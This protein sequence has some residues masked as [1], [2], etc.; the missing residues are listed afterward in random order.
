MYQWCAMTEDP[1]H[2]RRRI[3]NRLERYLE[4]RGAPR[5]EMFIIVLG[6]AA[7][8]FLAS[9]GMLHA[10][11]TMIWL[12]YVLAASVAYVS[13]LSFV[14]LWLRYARGALAPD[15]NPLDAVDLVDAATELSPST[16]G[17]G[18]FDF[19]LS[20]EGCLVIVAAIAALTAIALT[21]GYMVLT[22]PAFFA[23]ILLDGALSY[24][25]YRRL[26]RLH[27]R[28]WLESAFEKTIVPFVCV[29]VFLALAGVAMHDY[30][31]DSDSIGDV[32]TKL[33]AP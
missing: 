2:V 7:V 16:D 30:A 19:D 9:V 21:A 5:F 32:W 28:H 8:G 20:A 29:V 31:P 6:T 15:L 33:T 22:A 11:V 13:F 18:S 24:G 14:W 27:R 4:R 17:L 25:L 1:R 10:G 23:E 12:R 26:R 3:L